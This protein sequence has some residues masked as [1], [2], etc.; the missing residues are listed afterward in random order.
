MALMK[1]QSNAETAN[2]K[3]CHN[4]TVYLS[5]RRAYQIIC[6]FLLL[7]MRN[8]ANLSVELV[9]LTSSVN[10]STYSS[11]EMYFKMAPSKNCISNALS[12]CL[13]HLYFPSRN[14]ISNAY[15]LVMAPL[16]CWLMITGVCFLTPLVVKLLK[17]KH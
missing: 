15:P 16:F 12:C 6:P 13:W 8:G 14:C 11:T 7:I 10:T 1:L 3:T 9:L 2:R 5:P 4:F 17:Y